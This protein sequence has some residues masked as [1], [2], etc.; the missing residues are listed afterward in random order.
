M[1]REAM[2]RA[3]IWK[4]TSESVVGRRGGTRAHEYRVKLAAKSG[5]ITTCAF[6]SVDSGR[7]LCGC[8]IFAA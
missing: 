4:I 5:R 8:L 3:A 7:V 2:P 6:A 1:I